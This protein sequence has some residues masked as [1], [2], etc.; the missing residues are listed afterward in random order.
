MIFLHILLAL[1][2]LVLLFVILWF[3]FYITCSLLV[4]TKKEYTENNKFYREALNFATLTGMVVLRIKL[5]VTGKE[6]LDKNQNYYFVSN[7]RSNLDPI[8][9]WYVFK[10]HNV[11]FMS[12]PEN[13]KVPIFGRIIHRCCFLPIAKDDIFQAMETVNKAAKI[14]EKGEISFGVYP[15]GKRHTEAEMAP[16]HNGVFRAAQKANKPIAVVAVKNADDINRNY[17]FNSTTIYIDVLEIIP[18]EEIKG[19]KTNIIGDRV[20]AILEEGLK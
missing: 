10:E 15:E 6:K 17:P 8:L 20:R 4:D 12:K 9:S 7:H 18:V 3:A 2:S 16:F 19:V 1:L 11:S 5:K 14:M 13:F